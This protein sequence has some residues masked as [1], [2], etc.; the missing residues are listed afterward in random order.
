M[1]TT[2]LRVALVL[3]TLTGNELRAGNRDV[4]RVHAILTDPNLGM[5]DP[6]VKPVYE[7]ANRGDFQ[8]VLEDILR[9]WKVE[10]QLLLYFSGHGK[11]VRG[12]YNLQFADGSR[13][14]FTNVL[15]D[16][17]TSG[18]DR[19][20]LI[21]DACYSGAAIGI[22]STGDLLE[23]LKKLDIPRGIAIVTSSRATEE[24]HEIK[25]EAASVFTDLFCKGIENGLDVPTE[26][27]LICV[28]D[29]VEYI[30]THLEI[31]EK[32]KR[33]RQHPVYSVQGADRKIWIAK[34]RCRRKKEQVPFQVGE[35]VTSLQDL[36]IRYEQT[37][38]TRHPCFDAR[39]DDLNWGLVEEFAEATK[40]G[41]AQNK[42]KE[43]ILEELRLFS[44]IQ[45][46]GK[47]FL[48]KSAV[49][50]FCDGPHD[51]YPQARA[52]FV[53]GKASDEQFVTKD[54]FGPLSK[55]V[56]LLVK[57]VRSNLDKVSVI[58]EDGLR[59]EVDEVESNVV[60]ELISNAI[61]HRN[62][63][64]NG[65]VQ[66]KI[67]PEA[68]EVENPGSFPP[69]ISWDILIKRRHT[70]N[71]VD[72][73]ISLYLRNVKGKP[74]EGIGRGF[75]V[76]KRYIKKNGRDSIVCEELPGPAVR[77]RVLR[78]RR[79]DL[80]GQALLQRL[81]VLEGRALLLS[82][83]RYI[84]EM[85]IGLAMF[86]VFFL[87]AIAIRWIGAKVGLLKFAMIFRVVELSF[88]VTGAILFALFTVG[89]TLAF[90]KGLLLS[91]RARIFSKEYRAKGDRK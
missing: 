63:E 30:R 58:S 9:D 25:D 90:T 88:T 83:V 77:I 23:P 1:Q 12:F 17:I 35:P 68:L 38:P 66:V 79:A 22:K 51:F 28:D 50:C 84:F 55:Q 80:E 62:Y 70:S 86:A 61:I 14:P 85:L 72:P 53:S 21:I 48:H 76:F 56:A 67:T 8:N 13:L 3:N 7:C 65:T 11:V 52:V 44:V 46:D 74:F 37:V 24:S 71:P 36:R 89:N 34:N 78:R 82:L 42:S 15:T 16:I 60:R 41:L 6:S 19:A 64:M 45:H 87:C 33:Y 31:E 18:V 47:R 81:T 54:I 69:N 29:I 4:S 27:D 59:R 32:Y 40:P 5:S 57:Q 43:N 73:T 20:I 49:L 10:N 26:D 39:I 91:F 2:P 75:E